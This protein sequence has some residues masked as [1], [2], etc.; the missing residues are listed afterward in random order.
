VSTAELDDLRVETRSLLG[1]LFFLAQAIEVLERDTQVGKVAI[2]PDETGVPLDW[3]QVTGELLHVR[4]AT[5]RPVDAVIAVRYRGSWFHIDDADLP[6]KST[7]SLLS[8]LFALQAG[9]TERLLAILT[10][11][12]GQ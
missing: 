5:A 11:P 3:G 12:I 7:F 9:K 4:A 2:T 8:Q 10:L 1:M 6:S